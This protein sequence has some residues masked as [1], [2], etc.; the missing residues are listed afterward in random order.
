MCVCLSQFLQ[1]PLTLE[2]I[3]GSNFLWICFCLELTFAL[4]NRLNLWLKIREHEQYGPSNWW[5]NITAFVWKL[6]KYMQSCP[7]QVSWKKIY[8]CHLGVRKSS[9][10][11]Q[12]SRLA[13]WPSNTHSKAPP[14]NWKG[15]ETES[16]VY[17]LLRFFYAIKS[18]SSPIS[19][20]LTLLTRPK[21]MPLSETW[22]DYTLYK[23]TTSEPLKLTPFPFMI[24]LWYLF[25]LYIYI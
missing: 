15:I 21:T 22:N 12:T 8:N 5:D 20:N 14:D 6:V 4:A 25:I 16:R 19:L 11:N 1:M 3:G 23:I 9:F 24:L 18:L 7:C 17:M 13:Q 10:M 2:I